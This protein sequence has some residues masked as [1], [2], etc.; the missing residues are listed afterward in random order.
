MV[1]EKKSHEKLKFSTNFFVLILYLL[2]Q[3]YFCSDSASDLYSQ[4]VTQLWNATYHLKTCFQMI[5]FSDQ[6]VFQMISF[7]DQT[8]FW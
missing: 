2:E 8:D 4:V 5:S 1:V 3:K 7:S 6:S